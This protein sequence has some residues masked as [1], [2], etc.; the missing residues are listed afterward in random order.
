MSKIQDTL[1]L[2][3]KKYGT[4]AIADF[5][6]KN[7][8]KIESISTGSISIDKALEISGIPRGR[9]TEIFG[10]SGTGK[11]SLAAHIASEAQKNGELVAY[12]DLENAVSTKYFTNLGVNVEDPNKFM[13][14]QSNSAEEAL[15]IVEMLVKSG[16]VGLIVIDSVSALI[17]EAEVNSDVSDQNIGLQARLMSKSMRRLSPML[18]NSKTCVV[19]INQIRSN[20][21]GYGHA[22]ATTT[23]GGRALKFYA[24]LRLE[25]ARIGQIKA[26]V[27]TV[28]GS[29]IKCKVV[30]SRVSSPFQEVLYDIIFGEG[31]SKERE[32]IELGTEN[33]L[34]KKGGAWFTYISDSG[35]E[36][37]TQGV[38]KFV[39]R[40]KEDTVLKEELLAKLKEV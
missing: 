1:E 35:E 29:R 21:G 10:D 26:G 5:S 24:S 6:G 37:K 32:I 16:E 40:L 39:I 9:I 30:K 7:T 11:T 33:G 36:I 38:E 34:I 23:S 19:F 22:P 25:L 13:L 15:D 31:I 14:C 18:M 27:D 17:P 2:I 28:I 3:K 8:H 4:G 12:L 20:I